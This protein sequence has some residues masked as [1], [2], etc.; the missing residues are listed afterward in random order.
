MCTDGFCPCHRGHFLHGPAGPVWDGW[1]HRRLEHTRTAICLVTES[2]LCGD[3][4]LVSVPV[5]RGCVH[6]CSELTLSGPLAGLSWSPMFQSYHETINQRRFTRHFLLPCGGSGVPAYGGDSPRQCPS[7]SPLSGVAIHRLFTSD[8]AQLAVQTISKPG[9]L[10]PPLLMNYGRLP[11]QRRRGSGQTGRSCRSQHCGRLSHLLTLG[12]DLMHTV[13]IGQWNS[14]VCFRP[15][16][17]AGH[18]ALRS[19]WVVCVTQSVGVPW[20]VGVPQS[21]VQSFPRFSRK[22]EPALQEE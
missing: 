11:V 22:P 17:S 14:A 16:P 20:S 6:T 10:I 3:C 4:P 18:L 8:L 9:Q 13:S 15:H 21:S 12:L 19:R 5:G 2:L 7:G 1:G